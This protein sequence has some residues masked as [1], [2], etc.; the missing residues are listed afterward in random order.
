MLGGW[1]RK[2]TKKKGWKN[3]FMY[4]TRSEAVFVAV[5]GI[6]G[7]VATLFMPIWVGSGAFGGCMVLGFFLAVTIIGIGSFIRS[8]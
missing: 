5:V 1:E 8:Y 3:M 6:A 7:M 4:F 2:E